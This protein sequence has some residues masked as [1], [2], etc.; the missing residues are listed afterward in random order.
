MRAS[1]AALLVALS[2]WLPEASARAQALMPG[3]KA[4]GSVAVHARIIPLPSGEWTVIASSGLDGGLFNPKFGRVYLAQMEGNRLARWVYVGTNMEWNQGGWK[5][6]KDVCDRKNV[7]AGYSDSMN[8]VRDAECWVLNH[9]GMTMGENPPQATIDFYRW[10]DN[11]GRPNTSL[12][13]SY[14]FAKRGDMLNVRYSFNPVIAGF[15]DTN[16][17]G[18]RG[19]P[20]HVDVASKDPKKLQ[21][22]RELKGIGEQKFG[23]LRG[24]LN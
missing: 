22:L 1:A 19:N 11:A 20:W 12:G 5:R 17:A 2:L 4:V 13:L 16:N 7:H 9:Y 18:W 14:F 10:S 3:M 8:S 24:V 6:D 21:Y 23:E 15:G